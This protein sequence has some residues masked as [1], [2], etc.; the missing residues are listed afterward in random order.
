MH[1]FQIWITLIIT[2]IVYVESA[3]K[4]S[5]DLGNKD[6]AIGDDLDEDDNFDVTEQT[7]TS[8]DYHKQDDIPQPST[9]VTV[10]DD[11][12]QSDQ[13][14]IEEFDGLQLLELY[15]EILEQIPEIIPDPTEYQDLD[16][17]I[18]SP[19]TDQPEEPQ[20]PIPEQP[21]ETTEPYSPIYLDETQEQAITQPQPSHQYYQPTQPTP[22]V[23]QQPDQYYVPP[24]IPP[25]SQTQP[26]YQY[27][28]PTTTQPPTQTENYYIPQL[29]D[30]TQQP[31]DYYTPPT[32]QAQVTQA[33]QPSYEYY[34][35]PSYSPYEISPLQQQPYPTPQLPQQP[36]PYPIPQLPQQPQPYPIPQ[37]PQQPQS[38]PI[39]QLPIQPQPHYPQAHYLGYPPQQPI[40]QPIQ[41]IPQ[42]PT[43]YVPPP[44]QQINLPPTQYMFPP[45]SQPT[46]TQPIYIPPAQYEI[47]EPAPVAPIL[48]TKKRKKTEKKT[49]LKC[50]TIILMKKNERG[51][52]VPMT[53]K[54]YKKMYY[55]RYKT[56]Y[57]LY[58]NLEQLF[59]DS[60]LAYEHKIGKHYPSILIEN[61]RL[62][63]FYIYF[64]DELTI[65]KQVNDNYWQTTECTIPYCFKFLTKNEKGQEVLIPRTFLDIDIGFY[66]AIKYIF[67]E[68]I[69]C[70]KIIVKD[71]LLWEKVEDDM[72]FPESIV[73]TKT[74]KIL[75]FFYDDIVLYLKKDGYYVHSSTRKRRPSKK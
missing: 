68:D 51:E 66:Q 65:V 25:L 57:E 43:H 35:P 42:P 74:G 45:T 50:R 53:E 13:L 22:Q 21:T 37:L 56:K 6:D 36:Q 72:G 34:Q 8:K 17:Y 59:C 67:T 38:Y 30:P 9:E 75:I 2:V 24:S 19:T 58:A 44:Q 23:P 14:E 49:R 40:V 63:E 69:K 55:S 1:V 62:R 4:S 32:I 28:Q 39:P 7:E 15:E 61:K 12:F 71:Q 11:D 46:P 47:Q 10:E 52:L 64:D 3:D 73:F 31:I 60:E 20:Q 16:K 41:L 27:Y 29:P 54:E 70:H 18:F 26:S 5:D 48:P 33:S